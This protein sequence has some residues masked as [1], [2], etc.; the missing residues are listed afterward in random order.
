MKDRVNTPTAIWK[1]EREKGR[2]TKQFRT[3]LQIRN[4]DW[5]QWKGCFLLIP[6]RGEQQI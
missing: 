6:Y 2:Q 5:E 4:Q 1:R 3:S